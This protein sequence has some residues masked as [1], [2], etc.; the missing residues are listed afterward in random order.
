MSRR[1]SALLAA[2]TVVSSVAA[3]QA[4]KLSAVADT[5]VDSDQP[6]MNFGADSFAEVG[7]LGF[8]KDAVER[9]LLTFDLSSLPAGTPINRARLRFV[10]TDAEPDPPEF[11]V[12]VLR[13]AG[14]FDENTVTWDTQPPAL[15]APSAMA[16][17]GETIGEVVDIDVTDLVR[18]QR[19]E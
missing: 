5:F 7:V 13:L 6:T 8:P 18:A 16:L 2:V 12:T 4:Q 10:L 9:A 3:T 14:G 15:P 19:A 11:A 17:I 1:F